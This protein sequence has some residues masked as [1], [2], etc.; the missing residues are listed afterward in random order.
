[1]HFWFWPKKEVIAYHFNA[2]RRR[3]SCSPSSRSDRRCEG[4]GRRLAHCRG[5]CAD[6]VVNASGRGITKKLVVHRWKG[7]GSPKE[8]LAVR[9]ARGEIFGK[10]CCLLF[11]LCVS[12]FLCFVLGCFFCLFF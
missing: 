9:T 12:L 10:F 5:M 1:M 11:C 2:A 8:A 4:R 3:P 6:T 7:K